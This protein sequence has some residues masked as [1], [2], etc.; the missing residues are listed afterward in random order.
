MKL[1]YLRC[2]QSSRKKL[3]MASC[4]K[5]P[6]VLDCRYLERTIQELLNH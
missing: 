6:G 1:L 3:L 4:T 5:F 2:N